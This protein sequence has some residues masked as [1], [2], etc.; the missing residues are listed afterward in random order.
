M[1]PRIFLQ[2]ILNKRNG[3]R[4]T[5]R[6]NYIP[7]V[8]MRIQ[9]AAR[10]C[11]ITACISRG[12]ANCTCRLS[13]YFP[14]HSLPP[15]PLAFARRGAARRRRCAENGCSRHTGDPLGIPFVTT[16]AAEGEI[17]LSRDRALNSLAPPAA[18]L[19]A[20]VGESSQSERDYGREQ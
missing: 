1:F 13:G 14:P 15:F 11:L 12:A 7:E 6:R 2:E 18:S 20:R 8:Q 4:G 9:R 5:T 19:F 16:T 17:D 10:P 3:K